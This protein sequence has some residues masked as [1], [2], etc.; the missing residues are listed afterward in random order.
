VQIR[1]AG[2]KTAQSKLSEATAS[3]GDTSIARIS[4]IIQAERRATDKSL[5]VIINEG[6]KSSLQHGTADNKIYG[7]KAI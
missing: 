1:E 7:V 3:N 5:G 4:L 2:F 6:R